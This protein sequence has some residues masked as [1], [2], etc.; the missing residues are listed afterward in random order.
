MLQGRKEEQVKQGSDI[1]GS[2][3]AKRGIGLSKHDASD[4]LERLK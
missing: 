1:P 3:L 4:C 2:L